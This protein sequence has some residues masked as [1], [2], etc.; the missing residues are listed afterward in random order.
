MLF[1]RAIFLLQSREKLGFPPTK[2]RSER[3]HLV[4]FLWS[5]VAVECLEA[6]DERIHNSEVGTVIPPA[7]LLPPKQNLDAPAFAA[8]PRRGDELRVAGFLR[9]VD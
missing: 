1:V 2:V 9:G 4:A 3:L 8:W 6:L 5:I 7:H